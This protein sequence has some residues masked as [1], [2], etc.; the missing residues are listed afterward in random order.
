M[1]KKLLTKGEIES[2]EFYMIRLQHLEERIA[3]RHNFPN[4]FD[5]DNPLTL[6]CREIQGAI[7]C[8]QNIIGEGLTDKEVE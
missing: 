6:P 4:E 2:L 3:K 8:I 5:A 7:M 1:G